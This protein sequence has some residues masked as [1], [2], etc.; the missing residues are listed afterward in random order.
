MERLRPLSNLSCVVVPFTAVGDMADT[1]KQ[2]GIATT[3]AMRARDA[4]PLYV[5]A[6][7]NAVK[8]VGELR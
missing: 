1:S 2:R 6:E 5:R 3:V 4:L 7:L 8:T